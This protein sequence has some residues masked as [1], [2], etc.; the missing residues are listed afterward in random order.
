MPDRSTKIVIMDEKGGDLAKAVKKA[1]RRNGLSNAYIMEVCV[2]ARASAAG[3]S[4][5]RSSQSL[6]CV[7]VCVCV[8]R[9]CVCARARACVYQ[10][11]PSRNLS[12]RHKQE[13]QK[14]L[15]PCLTER[16]IRR[17]HS[18]SCPHS[19]THRRVASRAGGQLGC[20]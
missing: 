12:S 19:L 20:P 1:L 2:R 18:P 15:P 11:L 4:A 14:A 3:C 6:W 16:R 5:A 13:H 17:S 9:V 8:W 7:C 10:Q